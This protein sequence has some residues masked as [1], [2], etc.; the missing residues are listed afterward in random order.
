[1][2]QSKYLVF[3]FRDF[4]KDT[5][6]EARENIRENTNLWISLD[7]RELIVYMMYLPATRKT[8]DKCFFMF[9]F[10]LTLCL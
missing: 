1:M 5:H 9:A 10:R 4:F 8:A 3:Y 2:T 6:D 7:T